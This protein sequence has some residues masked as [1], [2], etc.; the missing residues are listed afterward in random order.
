MAEGGRGSGASRPGGGFVD[1]SV[2]GGIVLMA[3][4]AFA[5]WATISLDWGRLAQMGPAV[6]PRSLA[7]LVAFCGALL[8]GYGLARRA[9]PFE[10]LT[11]RGPFMV[12]LAIVLFALT[13]RPVEISTGLWTPGL[14][15]VVA[16]PLAILVG[17]HA[18][19]EARNGELLALAFLL[20]PFCMVLFGDLLNLPIPVFPQALA[21]S[22]FAGW[23]NRAVLRIIATVMAVVGLA[24]AWVAF[25][26]ALAETGRGR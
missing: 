5:F 16:G 19:P 11:V 26:R 4:G 17:G 7:L 25:P 15:L 9:E 23:S 18:T 12:T 3:L 24:I 14:G 20:T 13:I 22:L 21:D 10:S 8:L 6:L 1:Q 2:I